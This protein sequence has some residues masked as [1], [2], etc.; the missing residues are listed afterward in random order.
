MGLRLGS[1]LQ[2]LLDPPGSTTLG[3]RKA[4]S[5]APSAAATSPALPP[6]STLSS[7]LATPSWTEPGLASGPDGWHRWHHPYTQALP[8]PSPI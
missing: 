5:D 6:A 7:T 2:S 4:R 8:H 1:R 3:P